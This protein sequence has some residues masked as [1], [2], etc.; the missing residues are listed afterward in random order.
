M[1]VK[2]TLL[3]LGQ[4]GTSIGLALAAHK[5]QVSLT[6]HDKSPQQTRQAQK[7]GAVDKISFN[8]PASVEGADLVVLA[9]PLDQVRETL[10]FIAP[11]LRPEAVVMDTSP[12]KSAVAGWAA[13]L[14]PAGRYYIGLLP[15]LNPACLDDPASGQAAARADLFQ[16]G[17]VAICPR[18]GTPEAAVKLAADFVSLLGAQPFF[19]DPAEVDGILAAATLLP[20]LVAA[21]LAETVTGQPGWPDIRK[22]AGRPYSTGT[23]PLDQEQ[24]AAL[25]KA[26]H[27]GRN[28]LLRLLDEYIAGLQSLRADVAAGETSSL[29]ERL[30]RLRR[31]RAKWQLERAQGDWLSVEFGRPELPTAGDFLKQQVGDWKKILGRRSKKTE[32]D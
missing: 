1:T 4:I 5:D 6:G 10:G 3:G 9:M 32:E 29:A 23:R 16:K 19:A 21:A 28:N 26:A 12:A 22:L 14:L 18:R 11:D 13:E 2:I 25:A 31:G 24:P 7:L 17:L 30:E 8:L 15:A 27:L 20:Q